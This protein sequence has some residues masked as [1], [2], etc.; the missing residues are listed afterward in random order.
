M[1]IVVLTGKDSYLRVERTRQLIQALEEAHGGVDRFELDGANAPLSAVLDELRSFGLLSAHKLV[2][3]DNAEVFMGQEER[4]RAMERYAEQPQAEST[5]LLRA[6]ARWN[7][8]RFDKLVEA[9]GGAVIKCDAP[10]HADAVRWCAVR[11]DKRWG[12]ALDAGAAELLVEKIGPDL[13]RLD[14]ELGKLA[15]A[16]GQGKGIT[17]ALVTEFVGLSREEQA[18]EI[19]GVLLREGTAAALAKLHELVHVGGVPEVMIGWSLVDIMRKV[20]DAARLLAAGQNESAV[21]KQLRLW[22]PAQALVLRTA[23]ALGGHAAARLLDLAVRTDAR[24]KSGGSADS[25]RTFEGL[26][27]MIG[28]EVA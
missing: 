25:M 15:A 27:V 2:I 26:V 18:W 5:L 12:A 13:A 20:H 11:A 17:R 21:A 14:S 9:G 6:A 22:G 28:K 3:V 7:P 8:G 24:T 23:R 10:S 4:R 19:Q 1:R 16:A